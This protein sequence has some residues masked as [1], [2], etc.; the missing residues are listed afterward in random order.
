VTKNDNGTWNWSLPT[1]SAID[2]QTVTITATDEDGG[3]S[4]VSFTINAVVTVVNSKVYHLR[5]SFAGSGVDAALDTGKV[6]AKSGP[7]ARTLS[8]ENLINSSRGIN[9]LVFDVAGLPSA[10]LSAS[11]FVFRM[12]PTG[13]FNEAANPPSSWALAPTPSAIVVL[14]GSDTT[15][16]RV[17]VEWADNAIANRWLQ[18]KLLDNANTGL[19][20]P[21]V[22][23]IGHLF[24]ETTGTLTGGAYLVQTADV[25]RI[26]PQVGNSATVSNVLDINKNGLIQI[27]DITGFR[28]QVGVLSLRNITIPEAGSGSEGEGPGR[29]SLRGSS[30]PLSG[31]G[32]TA[33]GTGMGL[34]SRSIAPRMTDRLYNEPSLVGLLPEVGGTAKASGQNTAVAS[35]MPSDR[36]GSDRRE[37][38]NAQAT[39]IESIDRA[40]SNLGEPF[41]EQLGDQLSGNW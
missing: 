21:D 37:A 36:N 15:P 16:A 13:S 39:D 30:A 31:S 6:L 4:N 1:T 22:Y 11:D 32:S 19:R 25:V 29:Q 18:I 40:F 23:Y 17:R 41:G 9:G 27:S 38:S 14:P 10:T 34:F 26:R 28:T 24:G 8:Y 2:N 3:S 35:P 12:S 20:T 33:G 5:S 7:A